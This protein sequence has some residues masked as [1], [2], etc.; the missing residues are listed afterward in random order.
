M[1]PLAFLT[2]AVILRQVENYWD[3]Q[4]LCGRVPYG[5]IKCSLAAV[6]SL[7]G[8]ATSDS[9]RSWPLATYGSTMLILFSR[10][11][12]SSCLWIQVKRKSLDISLSEGYPHDQRVDEQL[13]RQR[14]QLSLHTRAGIGLT[15][16]CNMSTT[17]WRSPVCMCLPSCSSSICNPHIRETKHMYLEELLTTIALSFPSSGILSLN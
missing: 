7:E 1:L 16:A 12:S 9:A 10:L 13:L 15:S 5:S 11:H 3:L 8:F 6:Q 17:S 2:R 4:C 14:N